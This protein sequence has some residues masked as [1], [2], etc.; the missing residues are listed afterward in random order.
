[1]LF[2]EAILAIRRGHTKRVLNSIAAAGRKRAQ[3]MIIGTEAISSD[4]D[5]EGVVEL[6]I[7]F[8]KSEVDSK[9]T[10]SIAEKAEMLAGVI[11]HLTTTQRIIVLR[12]MFRRIELKPSARDIVVALLTNGDVEDVTAILLKI[13]RCPWQLHYENHMEMCLA[14]KQAL[15]KSSIKVPDIYISWAQSRNFRVHFSKKEKVS[16]APDA[17]LP[18][19]NEGNRPLFIRLLAHA[20]VGLIRSG[21]DILLRSLLHHSFMTISGAA[22]IRMSEL[23]GDTALGVISMELDQAISARHAGTL[24]S[25]LRGAEESLYIRL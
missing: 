14:A 21:D 7:K 9:K 11:R 22:A 3:A 25:A 16:A 15:L 13:G 4:S 20:L 10:P 19:Q 23:I 12:S 24:A 1:V 8:N 6:Y 5:F 17:V 18:L 2:G